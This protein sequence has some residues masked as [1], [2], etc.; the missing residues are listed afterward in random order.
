M[1]KIKI[2]TAT[3]MVFSGR[4]YQQI[5][6]KMRQMD[7]KA[8]GIQHYMESVR[9]RYICLHKDDLINHDDCAQFITS[10]F[11][12]GYITSILKRK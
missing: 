1:T 9:K 12:A 11:Q 5:V 4:S 2:K 6:I 3:G 10:L 7:H 8:S